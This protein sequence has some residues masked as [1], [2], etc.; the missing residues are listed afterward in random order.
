MLKYLRFSFIATLCFLLTSESSYSQSIIYSYK[1]DS[2]RWVDSVFVQLTREQRIAQLMMVRAYSNK[3]EKFNASIDSLILNY[4]IGGLVFFQGGPVRQANLTN[5]WQKLSTVPLFIGID[6][7][8]GL[9]M[10]LDST[11]SFPDNFLLGAIAND[12]LIYYTAQRI[13]EHCKRLGVDINFAPVA[14]VN[15]N[16]LNPVI[17][18]RSFG[19]NPDLVALKTLSWLNGLQSAGIIGSLKHFPGHGDTETD[20]HQNLPV[21]TKSFAMLEQTELLP[22]RTSLPFADALMVGHLMVP[23]IDS[24]TG[25]PATLSEKIIQELLKNKMGFKG[26]IITDALDMKGVTKSS[27]PSELELKA[28]L[29]GNDMLLLPTDID[30]AVKSISTAIDSCL[31]DEQILNTAC[32]KVLSYKYKSLKFKSSE[33]QVKN[34]IAELNTRKDSLLRNTLYKNAI[35]LIK[36]CNKLLPLHDFTNLKTAFVPLVSSNESLES[37]LSLQMPVTTVSPPAIEDSASIA[38]FFTRLEN[39][40]LIIVEV[41]PPSVY[42]FKNFGLSSFTVKLMDSL[43]QTNKVVIV[44]QGNPYALSLFQSLE[45]AEAIIVGYQNKPEISSLIAKQ[46]IGSELFTGKLPVSATP[47]FKAGSGIKTNIAKVL[48]TIEPESVG[49]TRTELLEI[50]KIAIEGITQGAYPG[51]QVLLAKDGNIFYNKCFGIRSADD[52]VSVKPD[53]IYDI[54]SVTKVAATTLAVMKLFEENKL[55]LDKPVG[56]YVPVMNTRNKNKV[57]IDD[58][59]GHQAGFEAWIPFYNKTL[60]NGNHNPLYYQKSRTNNFNIKLDDSL[61]LRTD[62]QDTILKMIAENPLT[63]KGIYLYSDLGFILLKEAIERVTATTLDKYADSVIYQPLGLASTGFLPTEKYIR[64]RI[65]PTEYDS[66]LRKK[67]LTGEVNDRVA[68]M[69]GGVSGHAGLFSN[70]LDLAKIM[71]MLLWKGNYGGRTFFDS[72][73]VHKFTSRAFIKSENRRGLGFDK[74]PFHPDPNG[75]VCTSASSNS[76]GHSGYTGTYVW[77]DPNNGL[78]YIFL[79]NRVNPDAHNTKINKLNIRTR[80]HQRAYSLFNKNSKR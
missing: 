64:S 25:V 35:T 5:R 29:A 69:F 31:L 49:I 1:S 63:T 24:V 19:E 61:F 78:L 30:R 18:S 10:R 26:L 52:T 40:N 6:G 65:I 27:N 76:F 56:H 57:H 62:Y 11:F 53:N 72:T 38:S 12:S 43:V 21:I 67:L 68:A 13:G 28:L 14:D 7:E 48:R 15:S 59:M 74:P 34:L 33:I 66:I 54:A 39:F 73:T 80:I 32:K 58:I 36:N 37:E 79:S 47:G 75:P 60:V 44:L 17:N 50:D 9:G 4:N 41:S 22:F 3:D 70:A 8:T 46:I 16:P 51:C 55:S 42:R 2:A 45:K 23:A 20:S 77:A 71:Q